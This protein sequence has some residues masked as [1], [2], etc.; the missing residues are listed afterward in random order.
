[1]LL[2]QIFERETSKSS[3]ASA[4]SRAEAKLASA[5][6]ELKMIMRHA[7]SVFQSGIKPEYKSR[8]DKA[9][10]AVAT[11]VSELSHAKAIPDIAASMH[12]GQSEVAA[13]QAAY[14]P[15]VKKRDF[16]AAISKGFDDWGLLRTR[17]NG[18]E[19]LND[20]IH[21][22]AIEQTEDAT[23]PLDVAQLA[24]AF[25]VPARSMYKRL[26]QP[27]LFKTSMLMP[28]NM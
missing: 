5:K 17:F 1:M 11:A 14:T 21:D 6:D 26:E 16:G 13:T 2:Q 18:D 9:K 15:E 4:V 7:G 28:K 27:E 19:G 24:Q 12:K 20:A 22:A 23:Y 3:S 10:A 25:G 8:V